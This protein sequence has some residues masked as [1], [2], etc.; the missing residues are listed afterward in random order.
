VPFLADRN[1]GSSMP[2]TLVM[3]ANEAL[4]RPIIPNGL[5]LTKLDHAAFDAHQS[6]AAAMRLTDGRAASIGR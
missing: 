1:R 5:P 6:S 4:G 3:E 2:L